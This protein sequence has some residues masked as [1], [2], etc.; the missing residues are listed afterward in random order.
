MLD[1]GLALS[2]QTGMA[3]CGAMIFAGIASIEQDQDRSRSALNAGELVLREGALSHS[4]LHF[5]RDAID[6]SLKWRDWSEAS[7]YAGALEEYVR[8][9]PLPWASVM[10]E[11]GRALA[12]LG[13]GAPYERLR[14]VLERV[15][16]E[17][18]RARI[19]SSLAAVDAVLEG[20]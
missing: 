15:R 13:A 19:V 9:E 17:L 10:I 11:R 2:R 18:L 1:E 3:F 14:P 6:V 20:S 5:Y 16:T 7:R 4:H 8:A 12:A